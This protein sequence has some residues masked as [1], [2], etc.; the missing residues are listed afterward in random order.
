M[1]L[2]DPG[3]NPQHSIKPSKPSKFDLRNLP[4]ELWT[5]DDQ[6]KSRALR[7]WLEIEAFLKGRPKR[8]AHT[9]T[10]VTQLA[11]ESGCRNSIQER[12]TKKFIFKVITAGIHSRQLA[13]YRRRIIFLVPPWPASAPE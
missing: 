13:R 9:L 3:Y 7:F 5:L 2:I 4:P 8:E 12:E 10:I 6:E 11:K 1:T